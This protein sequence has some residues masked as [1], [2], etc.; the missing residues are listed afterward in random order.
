MMV[1]MNAMIMA[2]NTGYHVP[3]LCVDYCLELSHY[4]W[5]LS[6]GIIPTCGMRML[7]QDP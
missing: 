6:T 3:V 7:R 1:V 2:T 5:E 4:P